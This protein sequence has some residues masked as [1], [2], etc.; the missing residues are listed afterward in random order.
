MF[1]CKMSEIILNLK[2]EKAH[3]KNSVEYLLDEISNGGINIQNPDDLFPKYISIYNG[4]SL[5]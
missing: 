5:S 2:K 1:E 4:I 3:L